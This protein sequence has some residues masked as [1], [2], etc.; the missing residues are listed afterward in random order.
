MLLGTSPLSWVPSWSVHAPWCPCP[1]PRCQRS[2][3]SQWLPSRAPFPGTLSG[4]QISISSCLFDI[5][6]WISERSLNHNTE[7]KRFVFLLPALP[8]LLLV[9]PSQC[10]ASTSSLDFPWFSFIS[11]GLPQQVPADASSKPILHLSTS[12]PSHHCPPSWVYTDLFFG[13]LD[14]ASH[15][16]AKLKFILCL[17]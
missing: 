10:A 16:Y 9:S 2:S 14:S 4:I 8:F 5:C 13:P 17:P 3:V 1:L 11:S 6:I 7:K 15:D 12:L